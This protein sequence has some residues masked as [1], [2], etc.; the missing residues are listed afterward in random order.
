MWQ[1]RPKNLSHH[2]CLPGTA[3]AGSWNL[4][5][6]ARTQSRNTA[7]GCKHLNCWTKDPPFYIFV[8]LHLSAGMLWA[9]I[10][11][12]PLS[13]TF[14]GPGSSWCFYGMPAFGMKDELDPWHRPSRL[15]FTFSWCTWVIYLFCCHGICTFSISCI[16]FLVKLSENI[17]LFKVNENC[18]KQN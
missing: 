2:C 9:S 14:P 7:V 6:R 13:T 10:G 3:L 8:I 18:F 12:K 16:V 5:A 1:Q 4:G 15:N 11:W 17:N